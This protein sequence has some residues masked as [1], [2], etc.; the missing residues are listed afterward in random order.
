MT[1]W[2]KLL[3]QALPERLRLQEKEREEMRKLLRALHGD[4]PVKIKW[5]ISPCP[6]S[7]NPS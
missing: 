7:P 3:V 5:N 2:Q 6:D 1:D 4:P